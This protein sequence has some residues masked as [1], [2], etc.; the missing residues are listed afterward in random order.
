M[1][2]T[3]G[4]EEELLIVDAAGAPTPLGEQVQ[5]RAEGVD[6]EHE[7]KLE[8]VEISCE[9]VAD[10]ADAAAQLRRAR[11]AADDAARRTGARAV[12][13]GTSPFPDAPHNTPDER[14]RAMAQRFAAVAKRQLTCG[15]HVHVAVSSRDEG[16]GVLDRIRDWLPLLRAVSANS[17]Y[18]RGEDSGYASY[19]TVHWGQWPTAGP[20]APFGSVAHYDRE[21]ATLIDSGAALDVGMVY[22]DAR[23]SASF[24][25]V[26]IRVADVCTALADS[27]LIAALCRA[28]VATAASE[29]RAGHEPIGSS[30]A[31]LRAATW[32]AARFGCADRLVH[33]RGGM[34]V[35]AWAAIDALRDH[36]AAAL[37]DTGD[38]DLVDG[39]LR[40]VR[41]HGTGAE[42][43]RRQAHDGS[44][45]AGSLR[46]VV[47]A[48][49]DATLA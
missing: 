22:F 47:L 29:W 15:Q 12:A 20:S 35:D 18:W 39:G 34:L 44:L 36:V 9:P 16:V 14:Y 37:G 32:R 17:P 30:V 19:R 26:E 8:Q 41:E 11:R 48:A 5:A 25:T 42:W 13:I 49:A 7:F 31:V 38:A 24:P 1:Q 43:Q 28:L 46:S 2:R 23:L 3:L 33:P 40:R 4:V 21:V 45:R 10:L 6:L 27:I